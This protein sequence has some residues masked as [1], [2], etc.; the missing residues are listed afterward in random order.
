MKKL[1]CSLATKIF[2]ALLLAAIPFTGLAA[3]S[4]LD[5]YVHRPDANFHYDLVSQSKG[6]GYTAY[7]LSLTSQQYLTAAEVNRPIWTHWLTVIKPDVVSTHI[8]LLFIGGGDNGDGAPQQPDALASEIAVMTGAV[9]ATLSNVPNQPLIFHG[10]TEGREED[11]IIAYTWDKFLRTGDEK[12]PLRLPM[13]KAAVR[14]MDAVSLFLKSQPGGTT[15]DQYVV[16][17]ESKR[18][19]TTWTTA[20]VDR[21]VIAIMPLVI[22][23]LNIEPSFL[24]HYRVYGKFSSAVDDYAR[25]GIMQWTGTREYRDLMKIEEPFQYRDRLTMPKYLINAAGDQFFLPDSSQFYWDQLPGEKYLRY[26]PNADHSIKDKTDVGESMAAYFES[27]VHGT[28]RPRFTWKIQRD[29]VIMVD[30]ETAPRAVKVWRATNDKARDFRL[31]TIGPAYKSEELQPV[32]PGHYEARVPKPVTGYT[33]Y[34]VELTFPSGGKPS[35]GKYDF[36]FTTGVKVTPDVYPFAGP[37]FDPPAGSHPAARA[38]ERLV[39]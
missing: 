39:K 30:T 10:E 6:P 37:R 34:F 24:H 36:K 16:T 14:A 23:L 19:W 18:G 22:D 31:E 17:G 13:T 7:V 21:R 32:R 5:R 35:G 2:G 9:T 28:A 33:A 15:V 3:E 27:V 8:G 20:A 25:A 29:G 26:V 12:W 4:A 38:R 1:K 11:G